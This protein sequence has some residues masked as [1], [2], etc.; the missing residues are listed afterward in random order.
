[1]SALDFA[2][3]EERPAYV[4]FERRPIEDKAAT[5]AAGRSVSKDVDFALVT[6][7]YSKDCVEFKVE[8]WLRN[9]E[10]N[11]RNNRIP[12]KWM[13]HW[14]K[15]LEAWKN[16]HEVPLNGTAIRD[17]SSISPAQIQNL[18]AAGIRTIED[19]AGAND[20]GLKRVGMGGIELR[21]KAKAWLQA[22]EDHGPLV[23]EVSALKEENA[24]LK[25]S[26]D[27]LQAQVEKLLSHNQ[28]AQMTRETYQEPGISAGD[29]L[30]D[31]VAETPQAV[32]NT[33][34]T[35]YQQY[36]TKFGKKPHH[37]MKDETIIKALA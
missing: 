4:R 6:P 13:E 1:M 29:I 9:M 18:M 12:V 14:K 37:A 5:L 19:L 36:E 32:I 2:D 25:G 21:N 11:V 24:Q 17:W 30:D 26:I 28:Q 35:L 16:G 10:A 23:M 27:S 34:P 22:A 8:T 20:E 33:E 7:P 3:R 31:T 15:S